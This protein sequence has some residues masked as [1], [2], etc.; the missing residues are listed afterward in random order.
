MEA[1]KRDA[2]PSTLS[3]TVVDDEAEGETD[4]GSAARLWDKIEAG[5]ELETVGYEPQVERD[6]FDVLDM[7]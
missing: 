3:T 2:V 4:L 1:V 5:E 7:A 6:P